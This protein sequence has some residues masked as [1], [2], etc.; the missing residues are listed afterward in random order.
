MGNTLQHGQPTLLESGG[1][2]FFSQGFLKLYFIFQGQP[3]ISS[4]I[5]PQI[6]AYR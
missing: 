3:Y 4:Q 2:S 1:V 5:R 6:E